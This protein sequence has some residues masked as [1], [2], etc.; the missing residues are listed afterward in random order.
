MTV[1]SVIGKTLAQAEQALTQQHLSY[2]VKQADNA[3]FKA[4]VV[5]AQDPAATK[6]V[7][8]GSTVTL[9]VSNGAGQKAVPFDVTGKT[10]DA[11]TKEL[12]TLG[13]KV[14]TQPQAS[15]QPANTVITTNP[16]P[17]DQ[18]DVGSAITLIYSSGPA[19]IAIPDVHGLSQDQAFTVLR[20][21]GFT[22]PTGGGQET[23]AT[24]PAGQVTRTDPPAG[25][26]VAPNSVIRIFVSSGAP[27][28]TVPPEI[29]KS[30]T[31]AQ[32][33]LK[34][35]GFSVSR[36]NVVNRRE[37]RARRR[38]VARRRN[39]GPTR[40]QRRAQRRR[41]V[42]HH[43]PRRRPRTT[44]RDDRALARWYRAQRPPRAPVA[45][46]ARSLDRARLRSDAAP[47][48]GAPRRSRCSMT[49]WRSSRHQKRWRPRGPAR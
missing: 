16:A 14:K 19:P 37:R 3:F 27:T 22:N 43:D 25:Q 23:S 49:S 38:P 6:T 17:G 47:D 41:R 5:F 10:V 28:V 11:A 35:K 26:K 18:A 4:G 44:D 1:P 20:Q 24:V 32:A 2:D 12:Q 9:T 31:D 40:E 33:D 39:L 48:P 42:T 7:D 21:N 15:D 30:F 34:A 46:N 29:G 45:R 36:L 8:R 13:F